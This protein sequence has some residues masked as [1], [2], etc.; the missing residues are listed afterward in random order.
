METPIPDNPIGD[1]QIFF[2]KNGLGLPGY[3]FET[4]EKNFRSFIRL[5]PPF[6]KVFQKI[7][8]GLQANSKAD[9][10]VYDG[11]TLTFYSTW[12][13]NK[14]DAK[15]DVAIL[16]LESIDPNANSIYTNRPASSHEINNP[17]LLEMMYFWNK[18]KLRQLKEVF[19]LPADNEKLDCYLMEAFLHDSF[20]SGSD[21][22]QKK[23]KERFK[24]QSFGYR[25]LE[26]LGDSGW[27]FG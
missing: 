15:K 27:N 16:I 6:H 13:T 9:K 10:I 26:T 11:K 4:S 25:R 19:D 5:E 24:L 3:E 21:N 8:D 17:Q 20:G 2:Q 23:V 1:L 22:F 14:K 18:N 7:I 12:F